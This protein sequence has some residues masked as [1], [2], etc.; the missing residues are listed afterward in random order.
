MKD[1]I[2]IMYIG[3]N[4][5]CNFINYWLP[6]NNGTGG[7][8]CEGNTPNFENVTT[9]NAVH[10]ERFINQN[11][12][13][14]KSLLLSIEDKKIQTN[15]NLFKSLRFVNGYPPGHEKIN[16][17]GKRWGHLGGEVGT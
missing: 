17:W 10:F 14:Y 8:V 7:V 9:T 3:F 12:F 5:A 4:Y 2:F 13:L 15:Q 6:L 1:N 11:G 16:L